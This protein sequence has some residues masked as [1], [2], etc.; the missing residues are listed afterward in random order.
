MQNNALEAALAYCGRGFSVIPIR[1]DKKPYILWAEYQKRRATANEIKNWIQKW[2]DAMIGIVTGEI[3]GVLVVDCDSEA[4]YQ[5]IQEL[6]PDS[7][8]TCIAKTPRGYHIYLLY[9][10]DRQIGNATGIMP[11]VDVRGEGGY[12]IAPP[13]VNAEG[14]VY[15]WLPELSIAQIEPSPVPYNI[16]KLINSIKGNFGDSHT[17]SQKVT[18]S[19]IFDS[20]QRDDNLF[21]I[22]SCLAKTGNSEDY[23]RQTLTAITSSWGEHDETWINAKVASAF[24]RLSTHE[25]NIAEEVRKFLEVTTGHFLVTD[26]HTES[27]IVTKEDKHAVIVE[28]QRLCK[29]GIIEKYGDK[30]GCYR[31]IENNLDA[32]DWQTAQTDPLNL[33]WPFGIHN[34]VNLYPGNIAVLAGFPNSGKTALLFNFIRL[35][36]LQH[37]IHLFSSEGGAEELKMRLSKFDCPLD[38]W[39]FKAWDRSGDFADVIKP[40]AINIIDY[41]ELH[42]DFYKVGGI[43]KSISD[44]LKSGFALIAIQKNSGRDEGLGGARGLEKPR[45]YMAMEAGRLK[46]VKAK[47]WADSSSNPNGQ[48][49]RFKLVDGC[50]FVIESKWQRES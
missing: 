30:R 33:I 40:D 3:S 42:D 1:P 45:L 22:A 47:S 28:L 31:I 44:K 24:K 46:I 15:E 18:E 23:I 14:K 39:R 8:I 32:L 13:S 12:I 37:E 26:C 48:S 16:N 50:K 27:H 35:N 10:A 43:I 41:L 7:F 49:I 34:H 25:R 36:Q 19:H 6:L 9:P 5:K 2:P 21:H 11:G 17:K 29:A 20:G 38:S 4:A